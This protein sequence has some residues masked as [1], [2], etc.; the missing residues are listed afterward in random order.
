MLSKRE[1]AETDR[2]SVLHY[3]TRGGDGAGWKAVAAT[4]VVTEPPPPGGSDE[5]TPTQSPKDGVVKA[6]PKVMPAPAR[7]AVGSVRLSPTATAD[8]GVWGRYADYLSFTVP[9]GKP[10]SPHFE[11]GDFTSKLVDH[12]NGWDEDELQRSFSYRPVGEELPVF[13]L[14]NGGSLVTCTLEGIY[15]D[16]GRTAGNWIE[17]RAENTSGALLGGGRR[18][19][20]SLEEVWSVTAV[21]EVLKGGGP[22]TVLS[23]DAYGATKLS[24]KG[25]DWK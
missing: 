2:S 6:R 8:L 18:K 12:F 11:R 10:D 7:E 14:E 13:A 19:W 5:P 22:A 21:V 15:R 17:M 4:W 3:F 25:V 16:R 20:A 1:G 23:T 9:A 24:V